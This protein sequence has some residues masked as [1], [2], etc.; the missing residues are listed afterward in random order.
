MWSPGLTLQLS[1]SRDALPAMTSK[2]ACRR[3]SLNAFLMSISS[4]AQVLSS[5]CFSLSKSCRILSQTEVPSLRPPAHCRKLG[6]VDVKYA[7]HSSVME[8]AARDA[9]HLRKTLPQRSGLMPP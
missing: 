8:A 2:A 5:V 1:Y 7:A 6:N 4:R 3:A 9:K